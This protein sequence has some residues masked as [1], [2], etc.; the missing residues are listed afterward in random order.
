MYKTKEDKADAELRQVLTKSCADTGEASLTWSRRPKTQP[1]ST[2]GPAS[3]ASLYGTRSATLG[4]SSPLVDGDD[5]IL[6]SLVKTATRTSDSRVAPR[7]RKRNS[8][9]YSDRKSCKFF[10]T[11]SIYVCGDLKSSS[12]VVFGFI[13]T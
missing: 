2:N 10:H 4:S 6:E 3:P 8:T 11:N 9:R 12:S 13:A 7:E 1:T 5:E